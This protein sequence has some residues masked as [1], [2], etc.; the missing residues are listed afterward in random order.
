MDDKKSVS[1][2]CIDLSKAFDCIQ[3][4]IL[5]SK[6]QKLNLDSFFLNLL[7]SYI[8]GRKQAVSIEGFLSEF[9]LINVGSPQGG[10]LSGPFFDLYI[11]DIFSLNLNGKLILYCDDMSLVNYG[12]DS[13][14]LKLSMEEDLNNIQKWLQNHYLSP[15][16]TKTKYVLFQGRKRFEN[17]TELAMNINFNG[18][19]IERA[20]NVK[21]LGLIIDESLS[22]KN[23]IEAI[24]KRITP[25]M[26]ALRRARKFVTEKTAINLY[27][28]HVQSHLIYMNTI[29]SA[30]SL[31][32]MKSLEVLQRK[33]LR[34]VLRKSWF[35]G[36]DILY[37]I[38]LLPVSV[39]C[40]TNCCLQVF[41]IASNIIKNN[42]E[43]TLGSDLHNHI[44]RNRSDFTIRQCRT[45]QATQNFYVRA[46][47]SFNDLPQQIKKFHSLRLIKNRLR[48]HFFE[49][50]NDAN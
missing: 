38:K 3:F 31:G 44:T 24:K 16:V 17:F 18:T 1:L 33:A 30:L 36:K 4:N 19:V 20:E 49:I 29:W 13:K 45:V 48:E 42:I 15:N 46:F 26:Y 47:R 14:E 35:A 40:E 12:N 10:V 11:N 2:T 23:H 5:I 39:I 34:I 32:L 28:A 6:L 9:L 22:F 37:S 43:I 21:I 8:H 27:Y 41:K 7:I 50:Y 25:F